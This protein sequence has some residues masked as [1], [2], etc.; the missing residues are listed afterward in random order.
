MLWSGGFV[1]GWFGQLSNFE[2]SAAIRTFNV[3]RVLVLGN[4]ARARV[5]A[6]GGLVHHGAK[7]NLAILAQWFTEAAYARRAVLE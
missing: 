2:Q 3:F 6:G 5:P 4:Q 7:L 1:R